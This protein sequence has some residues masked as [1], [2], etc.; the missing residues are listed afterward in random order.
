MLKS[1][2]CVMCGTELIW[3]DKRRPHLHH[4]HETG[5]VKGFSHPLCN[6]AEG[7]LSKMTIIER[8]TFIREVFPEILR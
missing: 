7:M 5:E 6:Q 2:E 3:T 1:D 8:K 4:D